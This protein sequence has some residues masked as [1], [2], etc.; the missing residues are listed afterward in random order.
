MSKVHLDFTLIIPTLGTRETELKRLLR[1]LSESNFSC[2]IILVAP[3]SKLKLLRKLMNRYCLNLFA[4]IIQEG[5]DSTLVNAINKGL[6]LI[7]TKYW[8]W[9][10]DDDLIFLD[11]VSCIIN[12]LNECHRFSIGIGNCR[13][14]NQ[15]SK[16][17]FENKVT[18]FTIKFV[19]YGPNLIPQPSVIFRVE[20]IHKI[21]PLNNSYKFAFDQEFIMKNLELGQPYIHGR[22]LSQYHWSQNTLTSLNRL[23]SLRESFLIR[24]RFSDGFASRLLVLLFYPFTAIAVFASDLFFRFQF[25]N[26]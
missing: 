23:K 2:D 24:L 6:P 10:G 22:V 16:K 11:E 9:L 12:R 4:E 18:N 13:Y 17:T 5:P 7:N 3:K 25:R 8:N 19:K 1:I 21:G 14:Y 15:F 20:N 26:I